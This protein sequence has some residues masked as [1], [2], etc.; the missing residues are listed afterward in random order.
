MKEIRFENK[1]CL[2]PDH[3]YWIARD[4]DNCIYSYKD[5]PEL[6]DHCWSS[7]YYKSVEIIDDNLKDWKESLKEIDN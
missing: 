1:L 7:K 6:Y 4:S 2:I 3:H 5:K